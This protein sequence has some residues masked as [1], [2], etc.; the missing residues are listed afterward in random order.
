MPTYTL[1]PVGQD[2]P[3]PSTTFLLNS[4]S[5]TTVWESLQ[6]DP[7][8][9]YSPDSIYASTPLVP[10]AG[11]QE[12]NRVRLGPISGVIPT[13][14]AYVPGNTVVKIW[15]QAGGSLGPVDVPYFTSV[16]LTNQGGGATYASWSGVNI[17]STGSVLSFTLVP[18]G[19]LLSNPLD[20]W[21][22]W[23][24]TADPFAG[25]YRIITISSIRAVADLAIFSLPCGVNHSPAFLFLSDIFS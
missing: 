12:A 14:F 9:G 6:E 21:L 22:E 2:T 1:Y 5:Y 7:D 13:G 15:V 17:P 11:Y 20:L 4:S 19:I 23:T 8:A 3:W 10:N 16:R 24:V 18:S 25:S